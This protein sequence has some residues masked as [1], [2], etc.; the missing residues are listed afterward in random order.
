MEAEYFPEMRLNLDPAY[1]IE[2]ILNTILPRVKVKPSIVSDLYLMKLE[3]K[4]FQLADKISAPEEKLL[5]IFQAFRSLKRDEARKAIK[6]YLNQ[7][8]YKQSKLGDYK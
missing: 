6:E 2:V 3:C 8:R 7:P 1:R 4:A 5:E